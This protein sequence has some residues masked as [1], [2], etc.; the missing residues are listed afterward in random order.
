MV[1]NED[2]L[3]EFFGLCEMKLPDEPSMTGYVLGSIDG[4]GTAFLIGKNDA[5]C[6]ILAK[7][8][9][10]WATFPFSPQLRTELFSCVYL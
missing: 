5:L 9:V 2:N 1:D 8:A 4:S 6:L 7:D 10:N 3:G